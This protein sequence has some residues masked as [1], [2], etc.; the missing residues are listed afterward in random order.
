MLRQCW[1]PFE[2]HSVDGLVYIFTGLKHVQFLLKEQEEG[3]GNLNTEIHTYC[4]HT[5]TFTVTGWVGD[6][7]I[8][9]TH[10]HTF[11]HDIWLLAFM[12][13]FDDLTHR[14]WIK[15]SDLQLVHDVIGCCEHQTGSSDHT[16]TWSNG[17]SIPTVYT[18]VC[19]QCAWNTWVTY[20]KMCSIQMSAQHGIRHKSWR[21]FLSFFCP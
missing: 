20:K 17:N 15:S 4:T 12:A 19:A 2:Q 14:S 8:T 16:L 21:V 6:V 5:H 13:Q 11:I 18:V 1:W 10:T 9:F 7:L 3:F